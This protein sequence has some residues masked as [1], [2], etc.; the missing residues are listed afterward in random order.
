MD[1]V[2]RNVY[3]NPIIIIIIIIIKLYLY[4]IFHAKEYSKYITCTKK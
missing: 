2:N 3:A 4:S 1:K